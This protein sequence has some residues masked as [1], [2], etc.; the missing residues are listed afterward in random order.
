MVNLDQQELP[1]A[2]RES[3]VVGVAAAAAAEADIDPLERFDVDTSDPAERGDWGDPAE[4][5]DRDDSVELSDRG[6]S[7][8]RGDTVVVDALVGAVAVGAVGQSSL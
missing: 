3:L 4:H 1:K 6:D 2:V 7:A 8:E 5:G